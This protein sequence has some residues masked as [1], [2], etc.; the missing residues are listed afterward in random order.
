[1]H[2]GILAVAVRGVACALRIG[3][4]FHQP[5]RNGFAEPAAFFG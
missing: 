3:G 4:N 2:G 5:N 1:M